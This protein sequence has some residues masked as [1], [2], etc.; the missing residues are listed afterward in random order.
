MQGTA[1]DILRHSIL[2]GILSAFLILPLG[3]QQSAGP[4][5]ASAFKGELIFEIGQGLEAK[6]A[7]I[8]RDN[9]LPPGW[10]ASLMQTGSGSGDRPVSGGAAQG[11]ENSPKASL[12]WRVI[13][14]APPPDAL[15]ILIA[16]RWKAAPLSF[17]DSRAV[18]SRADAEKIGLVDIGQII[19]PRRAAAVD[20]LWPGEAGYPFEEWLE[21]TVYEARDEL[22]VWA[23]DLG[24]KYASAASQTLPGGV[25]RPLVLGAVGDIVFGDTEAPLLSRGEDGL[26]KLF[27]SVLPIMRKDDILVGNLEGVVSE[28]GQGN[29]RKRFQFRFPLS[30]PAALQK[31]GFDLVLAGNNHV[32]DYGTEA[33]EDSLLN[34]ASAGLPAV[35]AGM[36]LEQALESASTGGVLGANTGPLFIGFGSFPTENYGFTTA[37]AAAGAAKPG[38]NADED[39][40]VRAISKLA[41]TGRMV[42]VLAHG[43]N[44]YRFEPAKDIR[45]RYRRFID[46]GAAAV[47]GSHPH[48]LQGAEAYRGG[49]IAYSLG[50]FIFTADKEPAESRPSA[51]LELLI[52]GGRVRGMRLVPVRAE[53]HATFLDPSPDNTWKSFLKLSSQIVQ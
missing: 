5:Q 1:S 30:T 34:L 29:P 28:H 10:Q 4:A 24:R 26:K 44:E 47:I 45:R 50:N 8:L 21:L 23:E 48:V 42:I 17:L 7:G 33:F 31:A 27:G 39:A 38:I 9:P 19:L 11:T 52:C 32:F 22:A 40:T 14:A 18:V 36:T 6:A 43:G 35:G 46:A 13:T 49:F 12:A 20:G 3:A 51:L 37:E 53:E 41:K 25:E 2:A 16:R 15:R